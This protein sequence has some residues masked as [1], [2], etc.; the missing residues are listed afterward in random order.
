VTSAAPTI[1]TSP[2]PSL[3]P[4]FRTLDAC[5]LAPAILDPIRQ[6]WATLQTLHT[7]EIRPQHLQRLGATLSTQL[8]LSRNRHLADAAALNASIDAEQQRVHASLDARHQIVRDFWAVWAKGKREYAAN[9]QAL[10]EP[11]PYRGLVRA[12]LREVQFDPKDAN[13]AEG[14]SQSAQKRLDAISSNA[15]RSLLE[16]YANDADAFCR[17]HPDLLDNTALPLP[18]PPALPPFAEPIS[19]LTNPI[20]RF[21]LLRQCFYGGVMASAITG[22]VVPDFLGELVSPAAF[23][24][25][26][27]GGYQF[28]CTTK[29]QATMKELQSLLSDRQRAFS[30]FTL[31]QWENTVADFERHIRDRIDTNSRSR[32]NELET[33]L[34]ELKRKR[35][36]ARADADRLFGL[37]T[38]AFRRVEALRQALAITGWPGDRQ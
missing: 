31:L 23:I 16:T 24:L 13:S 18:R 5:S 25:G 1:T 4:V 19:D 28:F 30:R 9:I 29:H 36:S 6:Q 32:R 7:S 14:A 15:S 22:M 33:H 11:S 26:V 17:Q 38:D 37:L 8:T 2:L 35:D 27:T 21:E 20:T 3:D 10:L 12:V 34:I